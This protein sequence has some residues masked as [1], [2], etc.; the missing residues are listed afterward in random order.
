[1]KS[2]TCTW[3]MSMLLGGMAACEVTAE[4]IKTW[5]DSEEGAPKLR[6]ALRD[7]SHAVSIRVLATEALIELGQA[8][9][10]GEDLRALADA[11]RRQLTDALAGKLIAQM[12]GAA[13][14]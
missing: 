9:F 13:A 6:A 4:K 12:M 14:G 11:D 8:A 1:M 5:R 7:P 10:V 3:L 2:A